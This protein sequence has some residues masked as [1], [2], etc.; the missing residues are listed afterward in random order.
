MQKKKTAAFR[1]YD[2]DMPVGKWSQRFFLEVSAIQQ[3][4]FHPV[5]LG[6]LLL[7]ALSLS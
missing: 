2:A 3:Y 1:D 5:S 4:Q 6:A 7:R